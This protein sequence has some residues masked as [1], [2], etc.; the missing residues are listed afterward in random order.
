MV[1]SIYARHT[2]E[3][4]PVDK[5]NASLY[6]QVWMKEEILLRLRQGS[7]ISGEELAHTFGVTRTA[8]WKHINE[9]RAEGYEI[10][11]SPSKGYL[12]LSTPD[13]PSPTE[14][15]SGLRTHTIGKEIRFFPELPSTQDEA[16]ALAMQGAPEGTVV[17]AETQTAGRGRIG[18]SWA[19]PAGGIYLSIILRPTIAPPEAL[20]FPLIAGVAVSQTIERVTRL[21]ARLKWPNDVLINGRKVAGIL[22]EMNAE[23]DR[24]NF[25]I[26]GIGINVNTPPENLPAE[27]RETAAVLSIEAGRTISRVKLVQTLLT[28]FELLYDEFRKE[29]FEPIRR[30]WKALSE[31]LGTMVT[32]TFADQQVHG[33]AFDIDPDGALLIQKWN[34]N[35]ER[36]V[37]GDVSLRKAPAPWKG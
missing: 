6:D 32:V 10:D 8:I 5:G 25:I 26:V 21:S 23:M 31:T 14:I 35:L 12:L 18:R 9:L 37:A 29:G 19:A 36:V 27:L 16:R 2:R 30:R 34:G 20:R 4:E 11:S 15:K 13:I 17:I 22:T 24:I 28:E 7:R 3:S 33:R 1:L